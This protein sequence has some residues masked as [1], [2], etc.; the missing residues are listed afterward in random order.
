MTFPNALKGVR[1][2]HRAAVLT[3]VSSVLL[4]ASAAAVALFLAFKQDVDT[5]VGGGVLAIVAML[6]G[7]GSIVV[8]VVATIIEIVG[9]EQ[10]GKDE[11]LCEL[12]TT[13]PR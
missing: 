8:L 11:R 6:A 1:N 2:M 7:L 3:I 4:A 10:A 12:P 5:N 9:Y 13:C